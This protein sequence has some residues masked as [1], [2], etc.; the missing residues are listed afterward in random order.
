MRTF[1]RHLEV[2][3]VGTA[4]VAYF[5]RPR[6][7]DG[8]EHDELAEELREV[9]Q[10]H[11]PKM[12]VLNLRNVV[13]LPSAVLSHLVTF[14]VRLAKEGRLLA[15]TNLRPEIAEILRIAALDRWFD[16]YPDERDALAACAE[17]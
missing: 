4:V 11:R 13:F 2:R 5:V 3:R 1:F 8:S 10:Q 9:V 17:K 15:L 6:I 7:L 12:L 14:K 16:I